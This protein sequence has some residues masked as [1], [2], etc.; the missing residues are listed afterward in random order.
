V[1]NW[2]K[3]NKTL[4]EDNLKLTMSIKSLEAELKVLRDQLQQKVQEISEED[5]SKKLIESLESQIK[6]LDKN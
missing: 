3:Q 1:G 2:R 5:V 6:L 4:S